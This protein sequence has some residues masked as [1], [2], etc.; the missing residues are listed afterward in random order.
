MSLRVSIRSLLA[1][2]SSF[3]CSQLV[4]LLCCFALALFLLEDA[5]LYDD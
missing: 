2:P 3:L 4:F 5:D 1:N